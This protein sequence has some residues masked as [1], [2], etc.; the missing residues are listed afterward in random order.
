[1]KPAKKSLPLLSR[2]LWL[3]NIARRVRSNLLLLDEFVS[4]AQARD[5]P[6]DND[7]RPPIPIS[8]A[9]AFDFGFESDESRQKKM[10]E[11]R[12]ALGWRIS[13]LEE[14]FYVRVLTG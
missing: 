1:M 6:H 7:N 12:Y 9:L 2:W 3:A 13:R 5:L 11:S 8:E 10:G 4:P 14:C